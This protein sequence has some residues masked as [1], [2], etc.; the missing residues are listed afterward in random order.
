MRG[1]NLSDAANAL[2][3]AFEAALAECQIPLVTIPP[4]LVVTALNHMANFGTTAIDALDISYLQA[5]GLGDG[6]YALLE[7][8]RHDFFSSQMSSLP[9]LLAL[10]LG[11]A[12][13]ALQSVK[14][15]P[16][17]QNW[18]RCFRNDL[19]DLLAI[20]HTDFFG[21]PPQVRDSDNLPEGS[22]VL[23]TQGILRHAAE[24]I[25]LAFANLEPDPSGWRKGAIQLVKQA[26]CLAQETIADRLE[27]ANKS[28]QIGDLN[29]GGS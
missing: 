22:G 1:Q 6:A 5:S 2:R 28:L 19:F 23:W 27:A 17:Y 26:S 10:A 13:E 3:P 24:N 15:R 21:R 18:D 11:A 9:F 20:T 7:E 16:R 8:R 12:N 25:D 14:N 4:E 29:Q